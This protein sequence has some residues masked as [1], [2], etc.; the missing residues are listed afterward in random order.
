MSIYPELSY[1]QDFD[2]IKGIQFC[3]LGP[4]EIIKRSV[5]E[6]TKSETYN[7]NEPVYHGIFDPRMGV[8]DH[9]KICVT[10]EQKNTFCPGHFGHIVMAK[11]VF[12]VQ[13]FEIVRKV[14]RCVCFKCG[15]LLVDPD[16]DEV[17]AI[18]N[19][20][21][22][23]QKRWELIHKM[24]S[25]VKRCGHNRTDGCGVRIPTI[26]KEGVLKIGF[27]WRETDKN[28]KGP[29]TKQI[30]GAEDVLKI[31]RRIS[32]KDA[33]IMGFNK[34]YNRPEWMICTVLPVPPPAVRPSVRT[35]TGQRQED[36]LT[37]KLMMIVKCN[38]NLKMKI[39]K[40]TDKTTKEQI[41]MYAMLLQYEV[42]TMIDNSNPGIPPSTQRTGRPIRSLCERLK[43]KEGRIRGNLMGKRVDFSARSVITPDPNIS[44]DELGVPIKIVMNLTY[45]EIVNDFN[46][47]ELIAMVRNGPDIYPGAKFVRKTKDN[48]IKRLKNAEIR[49]SIE[50]ENGD[51]VER[52]LKNGDYVLFN[53]QPSLHRLSMLAHR[54]RVM[55]FNTFRLNVCV[56]PS[57]NADFDGD[58]MNLHASQSYQTH[59]ELKQLCSVPTQIISPREAKPIISIVQDIVSGLY[60]LTK[61]HVRISE[62]QM[63]NLMSTNSKFIGELPTPFNV[64]GQYS[65]WT[66]RQLLSTIIPDKV[67]LEI[68]TDAYNDDLPRDQNTSGLVK[69]VNGQ[70][71]SGTFTKDI[72]QARTTGLIHSIYNE[73]GPDE[74]RILFDNTQ[75]LIC[76]WLVL[77]GFSVGISDLIVDAST[78]DTFKEIIKKMKISVYDIIEGIHKG[79]FENMSTKTN[80]E[81]F[82]EVVNAKLNGAINEVGK[83]GRE[84]INENTNRLINMIKSKAKGNEVNVAQ[85]MGCVG[86]QNVDGKR[87]PY[88]FDDRTLPHYTKYDDGPDSRGFIEN[89]FINGLTPQEF[90]FAAMGGRE[91]LIDTAVQSVTGDTPIIILEDC[92][93]KY[94]RIGDWIDSLLKVNCNLV[95]NFE[96]RRMELLDL[97]RNANILISTTDMHGTVS[98][99]KIT[100]VTRHDPGTQLYQIK[101][102]S[103]RS[104]IVTD[105]KSLLI[106]NSENYIFEEVPTPSVKI[107]DYVPCTTNLLRPLDLIDTYDFMTLNKMNG[108][109]IGIYLADGF[110]NVKNGRICI[111][112]MDLDLRVFVRG[113][114]DK[115]DIKYTYTGKLVTIE[116]ISYGMVEF[117]EKI[118]GNKDK[119]VP[120]VAFSAPDEFIYGLLAGYFSCD[121]TVLRIDYIESGYTSKRIAEGIA[122]LCSRLNIFSHIQQ[123]GECT[124]RNSIGSHWARRF[125]LLIDFVSNKL[126][127][128]ATTSIFSSQLNSTNYMIRNDV[129]L[130]KIIEIN[131]LDSKAYP[132]VYDLTI[133]STLNFGLANGLQVRD[134]SETGYIQR[135]LVKAME[136]CKVNYDM[137]VRNANGN[138]IQFLYGDDGMDACKVESQV[139]STVDMDLDTIYKEY[140]ISADATELKY[141]VRDDIVTLCANDA[142]FKKAMTA[143][144]DQLIMDRHFVI[145]NMFKGE[146][147]HTVMYPVSLFRIL[148]NASALYAKYG[149]DTNLDLD[150]RKILTTINTLCTELFVNKNHSGT[151]LF[152]I[153]LR[154]YLSPKKILTRYKLNDTAFDYVIQQIKYR[155]YESMVHPS[156]MVGV[157][158][159]QSIGEPSTQLSMLKSCTVIIKTKD[160]I[161]KGPI[162]TFVD[163]LLDKNKE[164]VVA[165]E[166]EHSVVLDINRNQDQDQ[167]SIIGVSND[168]KTSWLRIS[169]VS[170]HLP[171]GGMVRIHTRSGKNTCATMSHSFLKRQETGI[172]PVLGSDLKIGDRIPIAKFIPEH[173]NALQE[174]TIESKIYK[175]DM[176]LG[177]FFGL[178]MVDGKVHKDN[179]LAS[180]LSANF[181][182]TLPAFVFESNIEFIRGIIQGYFDGNG[183][184]ASATGKGMIR[185]SSTNEQL[186]I[187]MIQLLSYI[188][189]FASKCVET[190]KT[191]KTLKTLKKDIHTLQISRTYAQLY[192]DDIGFTIDHKAEALDKVIEYQNRNDKK[193]HQCV[194]DKI[195]ELGNIIAFIGKNLGLKDQSRI[196]RRWINKKAIGRETLINYIDVFELANRVQNNAV[197]SE[198]IAIL[199]Q[200]AFGDVVWDEIIKIDYIDDPNEFVYDFTVPGNDSFMVDCNILVHNTL[201]TF[202]LSGISAASKA[203]RGV[204]RLNE[205]LSVSKSIKSPIMKVF[206]NESVHTNK[207]KC[208]ETMND[209][210]TV[211]FKDIVITSNIYFDPK[212]FNTNVREDTCFVDIYKEFLAVTG[213]KERTNLSPWLLRLKIDKSKMKDFNIVMIDLHHKL[214]AFYDSRISCMFSDDNA[215][216][217]IFRIKLEKQDDVVGDDLLTDLKALEHNIMETVVIKG[218]QKIENVSLSELKRENG[219]YNPITQQFEN[220]LEWII[221]TEGSN[222]R[223]VLSLDIVDGAR[224]LTNDVTEVYNVLGVEAARQVL[225]NEINE[226]LDNIHV[227]Y[228]HI[229]LLVDVMT[230]KGGILSVNRHG[231]NRGDIG[232][233]AK[234][235]FEESTDKL[236]KAGVFAEFD[237]LNGVA[238]NVMLGQI[239][240]CGTGDVRIIMDESRL[241][242]IPEDQWD[243]GNDDNKIDDAN[244]VCVDGNFKIDFEIPLIPDHLIEKMDNEVEII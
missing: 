60:C 147:E 159:A 173:P 179:D 22:S 40:A 180:F 187:D 80:H 105:S 24:C 232:P 188:G 244:S 20:K 31:L 203:V 183:N 155:F 101:T 12:Y 145:N 140:M 114:F 59:E 228:R 209:I 229:A 168:E 109:F 167:F 197:I 143:H 213:E 5:V 88:G 240:P 214:D 204:P 242:A 13:F 239:A 132:K 150:P 128:L 231:I 125:Y 207:I 171:H 118:V 10:C 129:V 144:V 102:M 77:N 235:A 192:K 141:L 66:G 84:Q 107:G 217:L 174:I 44:I 122:M 227:N 208:L 222:L 119:H 241:E 35:D 15:K 98:W 41:D 106:W 160:G 158:A 6:V 154:V 90:F 236:I 226:V 97:N 211:R 136:D 137:T 201:N 86:Q 233:L 64:Q 96:D 89:S 48:F 164:Q 220:Q 238:A 133:P 157:I 156:E 120:D 67:N 163:Q 195:P 78:S 193:T 121:T 199:K 46:R 18:G 221:Y 113:W 175:L 28:E 224:T 237:K 110:L 116:G 17:K 111:S 33:E 55:P 135:K 162:G 21:Y 172:V 115:F 189:I 7:V 223:H 139:I 170:R 176:K 75:K 148:T 52:H 149:C 138:I 82:E 112:S 142:S 8:I 230:N 108:I 191:L 39:E 186:I 3:I 27:E 71:L 117:L 178:F 94:V 216:E 212:D 131:V 177:C 124:Y 99:G 74:T 34:K 11:P 153:L 206:L 9:N 16:S 83:K 61:D 243:F 198:K 49:K 65:E 151:T 73:Y 202:H 219:K 234:C 62:K 194:I 185:A 68:K 181:S 57:Y 146:H 81:L 63:F 23:R 165:L 72:Y 2:R 196:Y 69:I 76:D 70:I 38:N 190:R 184:V 92:I 126:K 104:V 123:I 91:G 152:Q 87:I 93:P 36:D 134:T 85:M 25:R 100:A 53:R 14:L 127:K 47:E 95:R 43:S 32:D 182:N 161:Y 103:G 79:K 215:N 130:D 19:K 166:M 169:Q 45:P 210:R 1:D 4:D 26:T 37:H 29:V 205:L 225:F 218:V 42:A 30:L 200:A 50:I 54:V 58:E 56:T 51:I